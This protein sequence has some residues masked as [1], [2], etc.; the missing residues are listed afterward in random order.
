MLN[1]LL[2]HNVENNRLLQEDASKIV[3]ASF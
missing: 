1:F 2:Y 3:T